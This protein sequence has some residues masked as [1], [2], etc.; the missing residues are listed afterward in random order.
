MTD[1]FWPQTRITSVPDRR[2]ALSCN[3]TC[4]QLGVC[5]SDPQTVTSATGSEAGHCCIHRARTHPLG[6]SCARCGLLNP[7]RTAPR[8]EHRTTGHLADPEKQT[9]PG[10]AAAVRVPTSAGAAQGLVAGAL[11]WREPLASRAGKQCK[12]T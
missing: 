10:E 2:T 1:V 9:R 5:G 6:H 8:C 3:L 12:Q 7:S 4:P 11:S